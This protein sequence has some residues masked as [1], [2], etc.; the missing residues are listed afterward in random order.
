VVAAGR[1]AVDVPEVAHLDL[2]PVFARPDGA[3]CVDLKLLLAPADA[4]DTGFPRRL[5]PL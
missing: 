5:R 4:T 1:L 2:N 3:H